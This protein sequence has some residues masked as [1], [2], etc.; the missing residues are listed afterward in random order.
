MRQ[1]RGQISFEYV[2]I[3]TFGMLILVLAIYLFY[4]YSLNSSD[5]FIISRVEEMG[6][7]ISGDSQT[8]YYSTGK[9]SSVITEFNLPENIKQIYFVN[10]S[11]ESEIVIVYGLNRGVTESVFFVPIQIRGFYQDLTNFDK[12]TLF[13]NPEDFHTG[14]MRIKIT[15]VD[16]GVFLEEAI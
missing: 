11:E 9:G 7:V 14:K 15:N 5:S 13:L 16:G 4:S 1:K 12:T 10:S 8:L 3:V 2:A 6:S